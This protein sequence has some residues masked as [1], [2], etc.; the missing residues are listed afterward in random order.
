MEIKP[1][2]KVND[3]Y[4]H[5]TVKAGPIRKPRG[6]TAWLCQC[7]CGKEKEVRQSAL[8]S[9]LSNSCGCQRNKGRITSADTKELLKIRRSTQA[10]PRPQ[11]SITSA[12]TKQKLSEAATKR[13]AKRKELQGVSK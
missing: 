1:L 3:K 2:P 11:G 6:L 13:W 4:D 12:E 5:W 9:G 10:P 8:M 7:S